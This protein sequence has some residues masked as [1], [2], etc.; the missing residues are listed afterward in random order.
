MDNNQ[1]IETNSN[2]NSTSNPMDE[3]S[4]N[5]Q[6]VN[7]IGT[8][9]LFSDGFSFNFEFGGHKIL[10]WGS[11]K[12]GKE[13]VFVDGQV[14]GEKRSFTRRSVI[15]FTIGKDELEIEFHTVSLLTAELHCTLI[16]NGVHV[17]TQKQIPKYTANKKKSKWRIAFWFAIGFVFGF[18]AID[19]IVAFFS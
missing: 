7:Q 4:D 9:A 6:E 19:E 18:F 2:D 8:M 11:A 3:S 12:S 15:P 17:E 14:V 13:K 16:K 10:A 1:T 5:H